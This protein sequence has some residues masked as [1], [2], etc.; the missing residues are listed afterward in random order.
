MIWVTYKKNQFQP[1]RRLA[2]KPKLVAWMKE[3]TSNMPEKKY[4][5]LK[6]KKRILRVENMILNF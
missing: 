6:P 1:Q 5:R 4:Q 2:D 3:S